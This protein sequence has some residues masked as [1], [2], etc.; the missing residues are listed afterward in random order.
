MRKTTRELMNT[1]LVRPI[2]STSDSAFQEIGK[3]L[4]GKDPA[5][6]PYVILAPGHP[7]REGCHD[8]ILCPTDAKKSAQISSLSTLD[9][10]GARQFQRALQN[11]GRYAPAVDPDGKP[12]DLL[13]TAPYGTERVNAHSPLFNAFTGLVYARVMAKIP[14]MDHLL[15]KIVRSVE[16][17]NMDGVFDLKAMNAEGEGEYLLGPEFV[18]LMDFIVS[19]CLWAQLPL[20]APHRPFYDRRVQLY[21]ALDGK[22][23][24]LDMRKELKA[25]LE[26]FFDRH[27]QHAK[28]VSR[29]MKTE[30]A[31]AGETGKLT[32]ADIEAFSAPIA[33]PAGQCQINSQNN[34]R[35]RWRC[36][37]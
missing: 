28:H 14:R 22:D 11:M 13:S 19:T 10:E 34:A 31:H 37:Y 12:V 25:V 35:S 6:T 8:F 4:T 18:A 26:A 17:H 7:L 9:S 20:L 27:P 36:L 21:T 16:G 23:G 5:T 24:R 15:T 29:P 30:P 32:Q 3:L 33:S 1:L 2:S